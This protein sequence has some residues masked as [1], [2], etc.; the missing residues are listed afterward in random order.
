MIYLFL[1]GVFCGK[2]LINRLS[3]TEKVFDYGGTTLRVD[4]SESSDALPEYKSLSYVARED[5][6]GGLAFEFFTN[7]DNLKLVKNDA[8]PNTIELQYMPYKEDN[9]II[10]SSD[11]HRIRNAKLDGF[12]K[13]GSHSAILS[14]SL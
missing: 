3:V 7:S 10:I 9:A 11:D 1:I 2:E 4:K 12:Y 6:K 8:T 5:D 13:Q 14:F